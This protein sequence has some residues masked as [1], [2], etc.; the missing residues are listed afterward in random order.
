MK[1]INDIANWWWLNLGLD[2]LDS[3]G[4]YGHPIEDI[5]YNEAL[6]LSNLVYSS[7]WRLLS[8]NEVTLFLIYPDLTPL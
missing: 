2:L 8:N 1:I 5:G 3:I 6:L 7:Q 4:F